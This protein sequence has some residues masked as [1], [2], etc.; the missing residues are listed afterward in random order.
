MIY[1][2]AV[3]AQ[4]PDN[5]NLLLLRLVNRNSEFRPDFPCP[6][7]LLVSSTSRTRPIQ[8]C[9]RQCLGLLGRQ[10]LVPFLHGVH[11]VPE[12][13]SLACRL[14]MLVAWF[15]SSVLRRAMRLQVCAQAINWCWES[16]RQSLPVCA[17]GGKSGLHRARRQ[18]ASGR[19]EPMESATETIPPVKGKG[20]M[21]RQ[22]R[23]ALLVIAVAG[24]TPPGARPNRETKARPAP[25]PG[26]SL[27]ASG[28]RRPR[29]MIAHDRTRLIGRL[30]LLCTI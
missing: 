2:I 9:I 6:A 8:R 25:F 24:Q 30:F 18:I 20:E 23:T 29:G 19:R 3:H 11:G 17:G 14:H 5:G 10:V 7:R 1:N 15:I 13:L 28:D 27:K 22:E 12:Q 21:V 16:A 26:R 4:H